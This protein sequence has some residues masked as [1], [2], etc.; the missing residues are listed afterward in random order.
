MAKPIEDLLEAMRRQPAG[1]RFADAM[2]VAE[3]FFGPP[4]RSGSH[5]IFKMP[6]PGDPRI[7]LQE[8]TGGKAKA[9]QVRQILQAVDKLILLAGVRRQGKGKDDG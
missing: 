1:V 5:R 7:N 2:K 6:W 3:H 9:Y 4:R 8:G